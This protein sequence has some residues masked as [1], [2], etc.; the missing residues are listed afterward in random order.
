MRRLANRVTTK[1]QVTIPIEI[2]RVLGIEPHDAV[3]F[4]LEDGVVRLG[5]AQSITERTAGSLKH[6]GPPLSPQEE[7]RAV[8]LAIA[9]EA[10]RRGLPR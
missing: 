10:M 7:K 2:R 3:E 5:K 8:E 4:I 1:G 6:D 9:E